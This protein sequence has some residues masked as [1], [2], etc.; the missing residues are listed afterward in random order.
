MWYGYKVLGMILL[1]AYLYTYSLLRGV[2]FQIL[3]LS[4]Y[5][6]SP[7]MLHCSKHFWNTCWWIALSVVIT[8]LPM[9]SISSNVR[10]FKAQIIFG[11]SEKLFLFS[12]RLLN[13]KLLDRERL[14]SW[15]IWM[16]ENFIVGQISGFS[17]STALCNRLNISHNKLGWI[18]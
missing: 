7:T 11:K 12:N 9:S 3:P 18:V 6:L 14:M 17:L 8:F 2:T 16:V 10:P 15:N 1:Q 5:V 4:S 13:Q